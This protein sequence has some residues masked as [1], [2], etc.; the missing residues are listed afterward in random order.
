VVTEEGTGKLLQDVDVKINSAQA[1]FTNTDV[2]GKYQTG[3]ALAGTFDVTFTK[4]RYEP[5]TV[6]VDLSNG[7]LT[8]LNV[9]L[10]PLGLL[11]LS[12]LILDESTDLPVAGAEIFI[13]NNDTT[14]MLTTSADGRI[15]ISN[16]FYG[17][18]EIIAGK[19]GYHE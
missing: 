15:A 17:N 13:E 12:G 8:I 7:N 3:Q 9:S 16:Y 5:K 1:N 11:T 18:Q 19:W 10:K 4:Q 14:F 6:R 2:N